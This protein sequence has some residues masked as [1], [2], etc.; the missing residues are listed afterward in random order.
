ME[1]LPNRSRVRQPFGHRL[2][3]PLQ[4][5]LKLLEYVLHILERRRR[6]TVHVLDAW[7]ELFAFVYNPRNPLAD[8]LG[9]EDGE[10][11]GVQGFVAVLVF[12]GRGASGTGR[13]GRH[14]TGPGSC[15]LAVLQPVLHEWHVEL[16]E[17]RRLENVRIERHFVGGQAGGGQQRLDPWNRQR[18]A[19][20][21]HEVLPQP[22]PDVIV[23]ADVL[24]GFRNAVIVIDVVTI[25]SRRGWHTRVL[26]V[27]LLF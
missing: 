15:A 25:D 12:R 4:L 3:D 2:V 16:G 1:R 19:K 23:R 8:A 9:R 10:L 26:F 7:D 18:A 17:N 14:P 24:N 22:I 13:G 21:V 11:R 20:K 5:V 6:G 27:L